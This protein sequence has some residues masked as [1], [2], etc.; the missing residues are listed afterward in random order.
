M[1]KEE[2]ASKKRG[3]NKEIEYLWKVSTDDKLQFW[4]KESSQ[5]YLTNPT[6]GL[7]IPPA[8]GKVAG[9]KILAPELGSL[10]PLARN[11]VVSAG[12]ALQRSGYYHYRKP[13]KY[14]VVLYSLGG[15][16]KVRY[17][18]R[19]RLLKKGMYMFIPIG[20]KSDECVNL[21]FSEILWFNIKDSPGWRSDFGT[22]IRLG[23]SE[24]FSQMLSF[25]HAY[26]YLIYSSNK[27]D[28]CLLDLAA[29][30]MMRIIRLEARSGRMACDIDKSVE[31]VVL[32]VR[33]HPDKNWE[34]NRMAQEVGC[35][36]RAFERACISGFGMSFAKIV[37]VAR[38]E[39]AKSLLSD[40]GLPLDSVAKKTGYSTGFALSK[41]FKRYYG[42]SPRRFFGDF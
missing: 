2:P 3:K 30:C 38:M 31:K 17:D 39:M 34:S 22:D 19:E 29:S 5:R 8:R 27:R 36:R 6:P 37:L 26:D 41:A 14:H 7:P 12:I 21:S 9:A 10:D 33:K 13:E 35:S 11:G 16:L 4:N 25:A 28:L 40:G 23:K 20:C 18:G 24:F 15:S 32:K 1:K 42:L